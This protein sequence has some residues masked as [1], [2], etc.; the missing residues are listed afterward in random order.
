VRVL[1]T[2]TSSIISHQKNLPKLFYEK[3]EKL[4]GVSID[5]SYESKSF[6]QNRKT[7][8]HLTSK[9]L[10]SFY[11]IFPDATIFFIVSFTSSTSFNISF[12]DL[13]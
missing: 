5:T 13:S 7:H 6:Q 1:F 9:S 12:L 2:F 8:S 3:L 11:S 4:S 10:E